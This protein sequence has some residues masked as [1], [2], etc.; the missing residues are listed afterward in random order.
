MYFQKWLYI[1]YIVHFDAQ[2]VPD[3]VNVNAFEL[4]PVYFWYVIMIFLVLPYFPG[5]QA[6]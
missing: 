1:P 3:L 4:A 2:I 5:Q 6:A